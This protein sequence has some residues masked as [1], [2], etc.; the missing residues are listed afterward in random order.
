[1]EASHTMQVFGGEV[2]KTSDK[3]IFPRQLLTFPGI[4][5]HMFAMKGKLGRIMDDK[6]IEDSEL[7]H[8]AGVDLKTVK[9]A[10]ANR[11]SLRKKTKRL[12]LDGLNELLK[13][14][15][16]KEVGIEIFN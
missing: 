12:I 9:A 3:T 4:S 1:M 5:H 14:R 16:K 13:K 15:G 10:K 7:A 8:A 11:Q 6:L 2:G